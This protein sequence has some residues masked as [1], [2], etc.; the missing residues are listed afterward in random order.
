MMTGKKNP[1][2][3]GK[4]ARKRRFSSKT[5]VVLVSALVLSF[6]MVGGT[7]AWLSDDTGPVTNTLTMPEADIKIEEE[8]DGHIKKNVR[9]TN[10]GDVPVY[11]RV[12][13]VP[14]YQDDQGNIVF[15]DLHDSKPI[16]NGSAP[17]WKHRDAEFY[18]TLP[19]APGETTTNVVDEI[20]ENPNVTPP[21]GC[22]LHVRILAECIQAQGMKDGVPM[23]EA[24][25]W[26]VTV[27]PD[28]SLTVN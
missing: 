14:S 24:Q 19:L 21:E 6:S 17:N 11:V 2:Y 1:G 12:K 15:T 5:L 18:Y 4:Y 10:T 13:I 20:R 7:L 25:G 23:V 26:P 8:F 3:T 9:V 16:I 27:Q 28:G 22:T